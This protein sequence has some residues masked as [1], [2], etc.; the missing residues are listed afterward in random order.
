[1]NGSDNGSPTG[2]IVVPQKES[3]NPT[4]TMLSLDGTLSKELK[5]A[6]EKGQRSRDTSLDPEI[7]ELG[8][9]FERGSFR[10]SI[11]ETGKSESLEEQDEIPPDLYPSTDA[12]KSP[13]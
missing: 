1:M 7:V 4:N 10:H 13:T 9:E 6:M 5:I 2:S 11:T 3:N 12:L 8:A